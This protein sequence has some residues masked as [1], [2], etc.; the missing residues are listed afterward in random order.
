MFL[1]YRD[2]NPWKR[3]PVVTYGLIA[4]NVIVMIGVWQILGAGGEAAAS[5]LVMKYGLVPAH[6]EAHTLITH[7]FLHAGLLHLFFNMLFLWIFG[8]NVEDSLGSV[9]FLFFYLLG[10]V[11][12]GLAFVMFHQDSSTPCIGASGA[13]SAVLGAYVVFYPQN[14]IR[15]LVWL[16]VFYVQVVRVRAFVFVAIW[17]IFQFIF[18]FV[19]VSPGAKISIAHSAHLGGFVFGVLTG[20]LL[21]LTVVS[22]PVGVPEPA[23]RLRRKRNEEILRQR[24]RAE[25]E[26]ERTYRTR[27]GAPLR[28]VPTVPT[29][30]PA[31]DDRV[32]TA[33]ELLDQKSSLSEGAL[34][35]VIRTGGE[36]AGLHDLVPIIATAAGMPRAD[37]S[38]VIRKS[39]GFILQDVDMP[40]AQNVVYHLKMH[41]IDTL[42]IQQD[43][44]IP[45]P[46]ALVATTIGFDENGVQAARANKSLGASWPELAVACGGWVE[47]RVEARRLSDEE[48]L[49]F[50]LGRPIIGP[51]GQGLGQAGPGLHPPY[52][53]LVGPKHKQILTVDL[54]F[55]SPWRRVRFYPESARLGLMAER[56]DGPLKKVELL[57]GKMIQYA[58]H[59]SVNVVLRDYVKRG[60]HLPRGQ[61]TFTSEKA[62]DDYVF[63]LLQVRSF[64]GDISRL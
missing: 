10:A 28:I 54:V 22:E 41:G 8:D 7:A 2:D 11:I 16:F 25:E 31:E 39:H 59:G 62:F 15:V 61:F 46:S 34:F 18:F 38:R 17:F 43:R 20:A 37:V 4:A 1:P 56:P 36:E 64:V 14:R 9:Y 19:E 60:V 50:E 32:H 49:G 44:L 40:R 29:Y 12:A 42:T 30:D 63:W 13:V 26:K 57:I 51:Y 53:K 52:H 58:E 47:K 6:L 48:D 3:P 55:A 5:A 23:P 24:I 27:P 33:D 21:R 35:S 45:L